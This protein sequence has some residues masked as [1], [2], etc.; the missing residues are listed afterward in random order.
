MFDTSQIRW[1]IQW[2]SPT[3]KSMKRAHSTRT[4]SVYSQK[5]RTN[6]QLRISACFFPA[7]VGP[8]RWLGQWSAYHMR[9]T[10]VKFGRRSTSTALYQSTPW[11]TLSQRRLRMAYRPVVISAAFKT[12]EAT[13]SAVVRSTPTNRCG[14]E[15]K[16]MCCQTVT[17][18]TSPATQVTYRWRTA[19]TLKHSRLPVRRRRRLRL[20]ASPAVVSYTVVLCVTQSVSSSPFRT[21]SA[22][23][24][25]RRPP[26]VMACGTDRRQLRCSTDPAVRGRH[27]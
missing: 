21:R 6:V 11:I 20:G 13:R 8:C 15:R 22:Q 23:S 2:N 27:L 7:V 1:Q 14:I 9:G 4:N 24:D 26:A 3:A 10:R 18:E 5:R 17:P 12:F 16:V 19:I 25:G